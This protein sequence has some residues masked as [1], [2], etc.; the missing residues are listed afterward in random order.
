[1]ATAARMPWADVANSWLPGPDDSRG[2]S[3]PNRFAGAPG[4]QRIGGNVQRINADGIGVKWINDQNPIDA[5]DVWGEGAE[6]A[7]RSASTAG[8]GD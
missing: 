7:A 3:S 5:V 2:L 4:G 6:G 8:K 1:M